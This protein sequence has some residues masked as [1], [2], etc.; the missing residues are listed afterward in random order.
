MARTMVT[1]S[2]TIIIFFGA[3]TQQSGFFSVKEKKTPIV[4]PQQAFAA[5]AGAERSQDWRCFES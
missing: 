2:S 4:K 3:I 5:R 1:L